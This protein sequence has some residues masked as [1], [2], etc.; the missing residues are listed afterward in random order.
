[1]ERTFTINFHTSLYRD[2]QYT[3]RLNS[4]SLGATGGIVWEFLPGWAIGA[5]YQ[6]RQ[7]G[8]GSSKF[9]YIDSDS[10][11]T[12]KGTV[13]FPSTV[14]FGFFGTV[15]PRMRLVGDVLWTKWEDSQVIIDEVLPVTDTWKVSVGAE[16]QPAAG[17]METLY[18]RLY[19]RLGFSTQNHYLENQFGETPRITMVSAGLGVPLKGYDRR[20]DVAVQWGIRGD[21][22]K[23]GAKET[24]FGLSLTLESSEKWFVRRR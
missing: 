20:L 24:F 13:E 12:V 14:G 5:S 16:L 8:D 11:S 23:F 1:V 6:A 3:N 10:V 18:N 9:L 21:V 4:W 22:D 7:S 2:A 17:R 15:H 19:Y